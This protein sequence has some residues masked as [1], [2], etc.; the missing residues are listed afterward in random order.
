VNEGRPAILGQIDGQAKTKGLTIQP[1]GGTV[2]RYDAA[3]LADSAERI[4]ALGKRVISNVIEIGRLLIEC[5]E[6]CGHGN[7][8]PWLEA[9]FG[10]TERTAQRYISAAHELAGKYDKL[11]DLDVPISSLYLLAAPSTPEAARD[12][13]IERAKS[14]ERLKHEEVRAIIAAHSPAAVQEAAA[15]LRADDEKPRGGI[16]TGM[17]MHR[18]A[19]RGLDLYETP[20][21]A[22]SAL[23]D[24]ER[25]GD[26]TI[27]WECANGRGAISRVLRSRGYRVIATDIEDYG[28]DDARGGIDF[29]AQTAAPK[30]VTTILTNPP[31][32]HANEFVRHAL[33]LVP[34]VVI[35]ERLAFLAGMGRSDIIDGGQLARVH[36]FRNR[37]PMIHRDGWTG[38]RVNNSAMPLAWFVWDR[39]HRGPIEVRRISWKADDEEPNSGDDVGD[40]VG[41]GLDKPPW[42]RRPLP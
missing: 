21:P 15:L 22:V 42:L 25:F 41:D 2:A 13:I 31:F 30:G 24:D 9:E 35:L 36:V 27:F 29:L 38:P 12:E 5:K 37:L 10:W 34:R 39:H 26:E 32:M 18:H 17:A 7:W 1:T 14:G 16:A 3:F 19:E 4:R 23:L 8:L 11:S 33:S 40:D 28:A 6:R 20:E